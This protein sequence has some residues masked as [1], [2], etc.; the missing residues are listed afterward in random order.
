MIA[1]PVVRK[2]VVCKGVSLRPGGVD[3]TEMTSVL[4]SET[5]P[6]FPTRYPAF[7][8]FLE[9]SGCR[10]LVRGH[11]RVIEADTGNAIAGTPEHELPL[12]NDPLARR[13]FAFRILECRFPA[14]GLYWIQFWC[15]GIMLHEIDLTLR[16]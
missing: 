7:S 3:L 13:L 4:S 16:A 9:V 14:P 10:G 11:I 15:D 5:Q 8:V 1:P 6:P 2:M 12:P